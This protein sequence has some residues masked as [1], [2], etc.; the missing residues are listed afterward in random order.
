MNTS[1]KKSCLNSE[2]ENFIFLY[3]LMNLKSDSVPQYWSY[4]G[5]K[6]LL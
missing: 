3:N 2:S 5:I 4:D 1:F 6:S